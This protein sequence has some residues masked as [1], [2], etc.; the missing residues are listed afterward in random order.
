MP[1]PDMKVGTIS[2]AQQEHLRKLTN[3]AIL[4]GV[5]ILLSEYSQRGNSRRIQAAVDNL[6]AELAHLRE[7][8]Q[9]VKI[10]ED[11][12]EERDRREDRDEH[13]GPGEVPRMPK[14]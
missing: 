1:I 14:E 3:E 5:L 13:Q 9:I 7:L 2:T 8:K 11:M 4:V 12:F 6:A 10:L